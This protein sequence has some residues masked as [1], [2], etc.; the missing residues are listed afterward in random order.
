MLA[1]GEFSAGPSVDQHQFRI[2]G[3][4]SQKKIKKSYALA[5]L[6]RTVRRNALGSLDYRPDRRPA[7]TLT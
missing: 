7:I 5:P 2:P 4:P 1:Q 6:L 3:Q